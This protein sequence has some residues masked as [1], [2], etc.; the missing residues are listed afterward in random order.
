[1]R[2]NHQKE[3][4]IRGGAALS[5]GAEHAD[6]PLGTEPLDDRSRFAVNAIMWAIVVSVLTMK[7]SIF[8]VEIPILCAYGLILFLGLN[9]YVRISAIR[10]SLYFIAVGT[11]VLS[12]VANASNM[13]ILSLLSLMIF[14]GI[15]V[16][17][18]DLDRSAYFHLLRKFQTFALIVAG[19]IFFNWACNLAHQPWPNLNNIIPKNLQYGSYVYI[20]PIHYGSPYIKPNAIFFMETSLT[21]QFAALATVIEIC[22]F[23]RIKY[24]VALALATLLTFS[25]TGLLLVLMCSPFLV[26]YVPRRYL[27]IGVVALPVVFGVAYAVGLVDNALKR[28]DEFS[29]SHGSSGQGRFIEPYKMIAD[30]LDASAKDLMF[31]IGPGQGKKQSP[32]VHAA[33]VLLPPSTKVM[34]EYGLFSFIA[35]MIFTTVAIFSG[36][37]PFVVGWAML[38][39]YQLLNGSFLVPIVIVYCYYFAGAYTLPRPFATSSTGNRVQKLQSAVVAAE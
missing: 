13:S 26:P 6:L 36:G 15:F 38:I 28:S 12:T 39:Q 34:V 14:Y 3:A 18:I 32:T 17:S 2:A 24:L 9:G 5:D 23:R 22:F 25:G 4:V 30:S 20:Q 27:V 8:Q 31:G 7:I 21:G 29:Y 16:F 37:V 11:V 1:M 35:F 19:L 33:P 10:S